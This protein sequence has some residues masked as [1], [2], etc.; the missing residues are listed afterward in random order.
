MAL[1][2]GTK[3][4]NPGSGLLPAPAA[5]RARAK[6]LRFFSRGFYGQKYM[7]WERGYKWAAHQDWKRALNQ[8]QF[9][10]L[11]RGHEF[12]AIADAALAIEA[13][14]NLLFSFE[15]MA[16]RD[17]VRS[18]AGAAAFASGLYGFLY[19]PGA[20]ASKFEQWCQ[21]IDSL[22]RKQSRVLTWPI[23]T[24]FG[25]IALPRQHIYLKPRL[26]RLSP[27]PMG[28]ILHIAPGPPLLS[29]SWLGRIRGVAVPLWLACFTPP[30]PF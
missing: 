15:K 3:G 18:A 20:A 26:S 16:L 17:A 21:V 22:P 14:T 2:I 29:G 27:A 1:P 10:K 11:L 23:V 4:G 12:K 30:A 6:V 8:K 19:R 9:R 5:R 24:L 25:S 7:D 28:S 13:R